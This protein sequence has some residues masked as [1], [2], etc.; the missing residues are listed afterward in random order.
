MAAMEVILRSVLTVF[1]T[2]EKFLCL[3]EHILFY[4]VNV[5]KL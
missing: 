2:V 4:E 1:R 3:L 5:L